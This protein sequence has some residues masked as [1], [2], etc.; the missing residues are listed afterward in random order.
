[1]IIAIVSCSPTPGVNFSG[2]LELGV[3]KP[4]TLEKEEVKSYVL[5]LDSGTYLYGYVDQKTVDV[6][7][8]LKDPDGE[9]VRSYDGPAKGPE[10]FSF[11]I[12]RSGEYKLE[13][14]P[15][16]EGSGDYGVLIKSAEPIATDQEKR[17]DQIM[18]FYSGDA[19]GAVVGVMQEG[20]MIFTKAYGKA[21][22]T[23]DLD[24]ELDMPTNIG[25]VTK[26][27][28]AMA[29]L[30]LEKEGKLSLEDDV[31]KHIPEL[32]HLGEVV[33][34][35]N[36]LNHTNGWREVYNLMPITGWKGEDKL[37][38]EEVIKILQKQPE[39]QALPG[40]EFNYN[41]SAFIVAAEIVERVTEESFP[42][43]VK[44][45]IFEPLG[46]KN[47]Y[48]R[49]N[50]SSI[51]PRA[52]QGYS[53]G[54]DGFIESRDLD[55]SYGAGGIY[56]TPEDMVKWMNNFESASLG[57]KE[58]IEKL[59]TPG[60]LNNGDTM[61]YALGIGVSDYK[62]LKR[63]AHGG[64]DI[65]HRA[66]M[67]YFP[68]I[69]SGVVTM[70]NNASFPRS[71][72][73]RIAD[74]FFKD[75]YKEEEE[76]KEDEQEGSDGFSVDIETLRRYVGKFKATEISFVIEFKLEDGQL[77]A[78]PVGQSSLKMEPT[79][80][81]SFDYIGVEASI[82]FEGDGE[83]NFNK[84][85]HTQGGSDMEFERFPPFDPSPEQMEEYTGRFF[86]EELE[87]YYSIT[88]KDSALTAEHRNMEDIKLTPVEE[89]SFN[90]SA[91]FLREVAFQRDNRGNVNAFIV[92]NGRT[93]GIL[94]QRQ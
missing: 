14:K 15:F 60:I 30:L 2:D 88:V 33:K 71:N 53:N 86:S 25:S 64:A 77:V 43:Y 48:V 83:G 80:E 8:E 92:S 69:R 61:T 58:V 32:P 89:D 57:G 19:P 38:K 49:R 65:A 94:F 59:V 50:P 20:Q 45:N 39:F 23:H 56:T 29:I 31:R 46:M 74:L 36:I 90:G 52:T 10:N 7:V 72:A 66:I 55:A 17:V 21:N 35:R 37:L 13:V 63:Y 73:Y 34:I 79:S 28:T 4:G 3:E 11:E 26:Q 75:H 54:D 67:A 1:M 85:V 40:E 5:N 76:K 18:S 16:E 70:S 22:L 84:A 27:F 78:Y 68:E 51:I 24:F 47:S 42:D 44:K 12:E 62:G 93:K 82:V 41:N 91:F 87:T 6:V 9:L 81:N